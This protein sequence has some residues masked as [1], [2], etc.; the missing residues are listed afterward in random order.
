MENEKYCP[1]ASI[2]GGVGSKCIGENS[3]RGGLRIAARV[4]LLLR[5]EP[6]LKT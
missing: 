1:L 6:A 3:V 2:R 4:S 5:C